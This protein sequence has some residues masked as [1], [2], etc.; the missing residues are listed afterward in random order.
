ME[1]EDWRGISFLKRMERK[2]TF[3]SVMKKVEFE[4]KIVNRNYFLKNI[5]IFEKCT[6]YKT[7][8]LICLLPILLLVDPCNEGDRFTLLLES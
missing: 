8:E 6:N 1:V 2:N 7:I 5:K 3:C 4:R